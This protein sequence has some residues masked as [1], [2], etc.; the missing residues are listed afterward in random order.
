[1][2]VFF[3]LALV[4]ITSARRCETIQLP[5]FPFNTFNNSSREHRHPSPSLDRNPSE[6]QHLHGSVGTRF[7][8]PHAMT[9]LQVS[10]VAQNS[11]TLS[12]NNPDAY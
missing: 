5:C 9:I 8:Q 2:L 3:S 7:S 4:V 12:S 10:G 6:S 1:M 11:S